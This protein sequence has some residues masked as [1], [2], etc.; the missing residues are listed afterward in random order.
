MGPY[1]VAESKV[2]DEALEAV[3]A[4]PEIIEQME[5]L[6]EAPDLT[7]VITAQRDVLRLNIADQLDRT[8]QLYKRLHELLVD[9]MASDPSHLRKFRRLTVSWEKLSDVAGA[10]RELTATGPATT[11]RFRIEQVRALLNAAWERCVAAQRLVTA[12]PGTTATWGEARRRWLPKV[13]RKPRSGPPDWPADPWDALPSQAAIV[14]H[15][16]TR[17]E[18]QVKEELDRQRSSARERL[19]FRTL[20]TEWQSAQRDLSYTAESAVQG[21]VLTALN[22]AATEQFALNMRVRSLDGLRETITNEKVVIT[23]SFERLEAMIRQHAEGSFGIA[24]PRGGVG[25]STLIKFFTPASTPVRDSGTVRTDS[26]KRPRL[27][28]AVAAPVA[29]EP[30]DF[31]LHL[32]AEAC[33]AVLGPEA[34]LESEEIGRNEI[35]QWRSARAITGLCVALAGA[36]S[37]TVGAFLLNQAAPLLTAP[38]GWLSYLGLALT[39]VAAMLLTLVLVSIVRMTVPAGLWQSPGMS[40]AERAT[41]ERRLHYHRSAIATSSCLY[42]ALC[43]AIGLPLLTTAGGLGPGTWALLGGMG[44]LVLGVTLLLAGIRVTQFSMAVGAARH[45]T[46]GM[47]MRHFVESQ[48]VRDLRDLAW[49]KLRQIRY[50]QTLNSERST[51][52]KIGGTRQFPL[53]VDVGAKQGTTLAERTKTFPEIVAELR[54]F[55]ESA[56]NC[57]ELVIA[58][59]ELDKLKSAESVEDFL[60]DIKAVFGASRCFFLVSVSEEAAASF[61][62]RGKPFRDVFDSSFDDVITLQRLSMPTARKILYGLL[63]GWKEPFVALCYVLSG[64]LPRELLRSTRELVGRLDV[65]SDNDIHLVRAVPDLMQREAVARLWAIRHSLLRES[66]NPVGLDLLGQLECIE[67]KSATAAQFRQWHDELRSWIVQ[68][69]RTTPD[70][71]GSSQLL[72]AARLGCELA[73]FMLFAATV[74]E[75]F[76]E[77]LDATQLREA[78]TL[79]A[80]HK[81]LGK[82]ADA[83]QALSLSPWTS[84]GCIESFRKAWGM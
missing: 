14:A 82:L 11:E 51:V 2:L 26:P 8:R 45:F 70:P 27:G 12:G 63:L 71:G 23:S 20:E 49:N 13:R 66:C 80:G 10:I 78:E 65:A 72:P 9:E 69:G 67:P 24:G 19:D 1:Y 40:R 52:V 73:A 29:Y 3:R 41:K 30:R 81:S 22:V 50:E 17:V 74:I 58:V 21:L 28:V 42:L 60:N 57:Y 36:F 77:D 79:A 61:E 56:T 33:R 53:G 25:K 35:P 54:A 84:V 6:Q 55:L 43:A 7:Q 75:F 31:V 37:L 34:D 76:G 39:A 38:D 47:E 59:D 32:H 48:D 16:L 5:E 64:G 18:E 4:R 83:R 62:R 68:R 46:V 15:L 44:A